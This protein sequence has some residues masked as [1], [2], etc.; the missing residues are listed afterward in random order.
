MKFVNLYTQTEY[1]LLSS[2]IA[3]KRLINQAKEYQYPALAI[4]DKGMY[5]AIKFYQACK[6]HD[7]KP[8][9]G[10]R[11]ELDIKSVILLYAKS[12]QGYENLLKLASI[13]AISGVTLDSLR[14]HN[15]DLIC[16]LA[17]DE[18]D[19]IRLVLD[20]NLKLA[21]NHLQTY[22]DMYPDFYLGID[23][24]TQKMQTEFS[25]ILAFS[26][27]NYLKCVFLNKTNYLTKDDF[28]VYTTL[29][30]IDLGSN[31]YMA[32]EKEMH[33]YLLSPEEVIHKTS[34]YPQLLEN[35]IEISDKCNLTIPFGIYRLP[36]YPHPQSQEY[37]I[38]LCKVGL[39]KRLRNKQ[40]DFEK[41]KTRLFY[42]LDI[43]NKM[44][45][46]DYFLIVY[47]YVKYA[48]Q[49]D[50]LVGPGRGSAPGSL[51]SYCLGITEI[52]PIAFDLLFER[53][54]NPERISMP[55]ID[56]DFP[57]DKRDEVINY[58]GKRY[59]KLRVAN[60]T[61]FGTF[62]PRLALRDVARV[63]KFSE[64][65]LNI[66]LKD[67]P[68]MASSLQA[69]VNEN[70][71]LRLMMENDPEIAKL[72]GIA[73]K[74]EGL[75]RHTSTH[76]AGI[77]MADQDLVAYTPL[78]KGINNLFQTQYEAS[79]LEALGLVKMDIL[80]LRNLNII[81]SV[82][83][84][85]YQVTKKKLNINNIPLNDP[86][87]FAM[88][89]KGDTDGIFQLESPGMRNTL[90]NLKA[91]SF[92]DIVHAN[93]LFRPGPMEMIPTFIRGK[94]NHKVK[95]LHPDL[96]D[97]LGPTYGIIVFQEQI[98]L[99]AQKFAGYS[100]S[101]A[102]ILRRAVSKK[103]SQVLESERVRFVASAK[104]KGYDE[105]LSNEIYD[106]IVKFANYGFNK[107]HSVAYSLIAYQMS[108]LK[109]HYYIYFMA[110][111][112]TNS[113]GSINLLQRYVNDCRE[114]GVNILPPSINYSMG[115]FVVSPY[116]IYYSLLGING[117]GNTIVQK[118]LMER[119]AGL[120][121]SYEDFVYRTTHFVNK[122]MIASLIYAGCFDEFGL[123]RKNMI[124]SFDELSTS[125]DYRTLLGKQ[126]ITTK[127]ISD[128]FNFDEMV[129]LEKESL[130]FNLKYNLFIK[131]NPIK[132]KEKP[133]P[134]RNAMNNTI[135]K[136]LFIL[137]RVKEITTKN[138]EK[139]AF[140]ELYDDTAS[141]DGVLFPN[142]YQ[143]I[144]DK[145]TVGNGYL[146]LG[147]IE[148]RDGKRQVIFESVY[149][150]M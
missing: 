128:E 61:T 43:I 144:K 108:Y 45:F 39:N 106:Y 145:L 97:I 112:M 125:K 66:I 72:I 38:E 50:I 135:V 109:T 132:A 49:H 95:Y 85:I 8:I 54:L 110:V 89:A 37:L 129:V 2:S 42:E 40:V 136:I 93:A 82:L 83:D 134:I 28:E 86:K 101:M 150:V 59:G 79:D 78:Q 77:I 138:N 143:Q 99:I 113:I 119:E 107:N 1:S 64:S 63:L 126:V 52:D 5:G 25:K 96:K 149:N 130:G 18:S 55:D 32:T 103:N 33:S 120:F 51:V 111:L 74:L 41:Y 7:I 10:L 105:G 133:V 13:D 56:V 124:E 81:K 84:K 20:D 76:A 34:I 122:R 71:S 142:T 147:K 21:K 127:Q 115:E 146:G 88:I 148:E 17:S 65:R 114:K 116:G 19:V 16:V 139:M 4:T 48:K 80:G 118:I 58:I 68:N 23:L 104:K 87:V 73:L 140:L 62:G 26:Q 12:Y 53:F 6:A 75:P 30:C 102:D 60:I 141:I 9:I 67:V 36:K 46:S 90:R 117:V 27:D 31:Q 69:I 100:L 44:G 121:Q 11:L 29:R 98:M 22:L 92:M 14:K 15:L 3:L 94:F 123:T 47:D 131:L 35:T 91:S 70:Q 24:Q 137:K 57:D